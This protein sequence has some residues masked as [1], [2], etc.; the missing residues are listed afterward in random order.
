MVVEKEE[1]NIEEYLEKLFSEYGMEVKNEIQDFL[2]FYKDKWAFRLMILE[3]YLLNKE[4]NEIRISDIVDRAYGSAKIQGLIYKFHI[5]R[6]VYFSGKKD[7]QLK[8]KSVFNMGR[9]NARNIPSQLTK[10]GLYMQKVGNN[11]ELTPLGIALAKL[12]YFKFLSENNIKLEHLIKLKSHKRIT[13]ESLENIL[14]GLTLKKA[15]NMYLIEPYSSE[16][17]ETYKPTKFTNELV[18]FL[19]EHPNI[20]PASIKEYQIHFFNT[21]KQELLKQLQEK[22]YQKLTNNS[23]SVNEFENFSQ[24]DWIYEL[25][26]KNS[27]HDRYFKDWMFN[28]KEKSSVPILILK[29]GPGTGKSVWM[30]QKSFELLNFTIKN[31]VIDEKIKII[32]ILISL[33][34][35]SIKKIKNLSYLAYKGII[36][37]KIDEIN[38]LEKLNYLNIFHLILSSFVKKTDS[39]FWIQT[40]LKLL[41]NP[42]ILV[43]LDGWDELD[44]Y[45]KPF[46]TELL[47][48]MSKSNNVQTIIST[49][50]IDPDLQ[51]FRINLETDKSI[52]KWQHPEENVIELE[53]PSKE[54]IDTYFRKI[55]SRIVNNRNYQ[56]ELK[57]RLGQDPTPLDLWLLGLFPEI[58]GLPINRAELY[59]RW[60]KYEVI[61]EFQE[62]LHSN[63][64]H[65]QSN[66]DLNKI[67][68]SSKPNLRRGDNKLFTLIQ[69]LEGP[70]IS[71]TPKSDKENYAILKLLP[72]IVFNRLK[73][74]NYYFN[75]DQI[76]ENN[77]LFNRF[78]YPEYSKTLRRNFRLINPHYDYFLAALHCFN[79]YIQGKQFNDLK[80]VEIKHF[81]KELLVTHSERRDFDI[82][83]DISDDAIILRN[84]FENLREFNDSQIGY[85]LTKSGP[86]LFKAKMKNFIDL[87]KEHLYLFYWNKLSLEKIG[88]PSEKI[89]PKFK[90]IDVSLVN[91]RQEVRRLLTNVLFFQNKFVNESHSLSDLFDSISIETPYLI[92][93]LCYAFDIHETF[94]LTPEQLKRLEKSRFI[95]IPWVKL[96]VY[97][98]LI[99]DEPDRICE[100]VEYALTQDHKYLLKFCVSNI[101]SPLTL[102]ITDKLF[103]LSLKLFHRLKNRRFRQILIFHWMSHQ[104]SPRQLNSLEKLQNNYLLEE[105]IRFDILNVLILQGRKPNIRFYWMKR[106]G[107]QNEKIFNFLLNLY[108]S[109]K[110]SNKEL[111]DW[112]F[113]LPLSCILFIHHTLSQDFLFWHHNKLIKPSEDFV[114]IMD[115]CLNAWWKQNT[116]YQRTDIAVFFEKK[117][118]KF[119]SIT[120]YTYKDELDLDFFQIQKY[121]DNFSA[122][123]DDDKDFIYQQG[124][125]FLVKLV[126]FEVEERKES[127]LSGLY[128]ER[129]FNVFA[130]WVLSSSDK[131]KIMNFYLKFQK[132]FKFTRF[133]FQSRKKYPNSDE[134]LQL[135]RN[136]VNANITNAVPKTHFDRRKKHPNLQ[137][138]PSSN[139]ILGEE[140]FLIFALPE[141][142]IY[143]ILNNTFDLSKNEDLFNF[144]YILSLIG[145]P[146]AFRHIATLW[147]ENYVDLIA[148]DS[149][150]KSLYIWCGIPHNYIETVFEYLMDP[151]SRIFYLVSM[152]I[153]DKFKPSDLNE[154]HSNFAKSNYILEKLRSIP[155][156]E[157]RKA[158]LLFLKA[159]WPLIHYEFLFYL[160]DFD[161]ELAELLLEKVKS[162]EI[163]LIQLQEHYP[164]GIK[165][166]KNLRTKQIDIFKLFFNNYPQLIEEIILES[167]LFQNKNERVRIFNQIIQIKHPYCI[168]LA[169]KL[170]ENYSE[171]IIESKIMTNPENLDYL[172]SRLLKVLTFVNST[173][174]YTYISK[175]M[176]NI[177]FFGLKELKLEDI[178]FIKHQLEQI[179][180]AI[181]QK[182]SEGILKY[183]K[184]GYHTAIEQIQK[185]R[186]SIKKFKRELYIKSCQFKEFVNYLKKFKKGRQNWVFNKRYPHYFRDS[187]SID[188]IVAKLAELRKLKGLI[189]GI[190]LFSDIEESISSKIESYDSIKEHLIKG[191]NQRSRKNSDWDHFE[192]ES[193]KFFNRTILKD[194]I[195]S[196][197][198]FNFKMYKSHFKQFLSKLSTK[199]AKLRALFYFF[200]KLLQ[201]KTIQTISISFIEKK[202]ARLKAYFS[203][204]GLGAEYGMMFKYFDLVLKEIRSE[205]NRDNS[206]PYDYNL[207]D[208]ER[209]YELI[210]RKEKE[211]L[212]KVMQKPLDIISI[213]SY[214]E[215]MGES[216]SLDKVIEL[217]LNQEQYP[218]QHYYWNTDEKEKYDKIPTKNRRLI[219]KY[220]FYIILRQRE[221]HQRNLSHDSEAYGDE[222]GIYETDTG[223][224]IDNLFDK[225]LENSIQYGYYDESLNLLKE[226]GK[227]KWL[228]QVKNYVYFNY[229]LKEKQINLIFNSFSK[230]KDFNFDQKTIFNYLSEL[231]INFLINFYFSRYYLNLIKSQLISFNQFWNGFKFAS[232]NT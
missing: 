151:I 134:I 127:Y 226:M 112:I 36:L 67:L 192:S 90:Q 163:E 154:K 193:K 18:D 3:Y 49:R 115:K 125:D 15:F 92:P 209:D 181:L 124:T 232:K 138:F 200:H 79:Q 223:I 16:S 54:Q 191:D 165:H 190:I 26:L 23:I 149:E 61:I 73:D 100:L 22:G 146:T 207:R 198:E 195:I 213:L 82:Q 62:R 221:L 50:Y 72:K 5:D 177:N 153:Y 107:I 185:L 55:K 222:S 170:W 45:L 178:N 69:L 2:D 179:E 110:F 85:P 30:I 171:L 160:V 35:F 231:E 211:I 13:F 201:V 131:L 173:N 56:E 77:S 4:A 83:H 8:N 14:K 128:S 208:D 87:Y 168:E 47:K 227:S 180:L 123:P 162:G 39:S 95:D 9:E 76:T 157:V 218:F 121:F 215:D 52:P 71:M 130:K 42:K 184:K 104:L 129:F 21:I 225:V 210:E 205:L 53:F 216:Y 46:F 12:F 158:L 20:D 217:F 109:N 142:E 51:V 176:T 74:P 140:N 29:S 214:F 206:I 33:R 98:E 182:K 111:E 116:P 148:S 156:K 152:S 84:K 27:S 167:F 7:E 17:D 70:I 203:N 24:I 103:D 25:G 58:N 28:N 147:E 38:K 99:K 113:N 97:R 159:D 189:K 186:G 204:L 78:I 75:F 132:E 126:K 228:E 118:E 174:N 101:I 144:V 60:I 19:L 64:I 137:E 37:I 91:E 229:G 65:I 66:Q 120:D 219:Q 59:E 145:T 114:K 89:L 10:Q 41:N 230:E 133:L 43:F 224:H 196:I 150:D 166:P 102:K 155:E 32:P 44:E 141:I 96:W 40:Y 86:L 93:I 143:Q 122:L 80:N 94:M 136:V 1:S 68:S 188:N 202:Y 161:F 135:V 187:T 212:E 164:I 34:H 105:I 106:D 197:E 175:L 6:W 81:F 220:L 183:Y 119:T 48:F 169:A 63:I 139:L 199:S 57:K 11:K 194:L 108:K 88:I 172:K 117:L 31:R